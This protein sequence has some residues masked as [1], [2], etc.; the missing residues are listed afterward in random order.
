MP[1]KISF[2]VDGVEKLSRAILDFD[3]GL[4]N[5]KPFYRDAIDIVHDRSKSIFANDGK[6]LVQWKW[7]PLKSSTIK[8]RSRGWWSYSQA[9]SKPWVLRW[10]GKLQDS[11]KK[12]ITNNS[13]QLSFTASYAP[14]HHN[15]TKTLPKRKLIELDPRTSAEIVRALQK[16]INKQ[17][18][19]SNLR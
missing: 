15:G 9:P 8:A 18:G 7:R 3:R 16:H 12:V 17:I 4:K 11:V 19:I 14:Y 6:N 5:M 1:I 2:S 13:G 10:T